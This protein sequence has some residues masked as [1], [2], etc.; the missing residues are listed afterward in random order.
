MIATRLRYLPTHDPLTL[1]VPMDLSQPTASGSDIKV[2]DWEMWGEEG[3][4]HLCELRLEFDGVF[5]CKSIAF[6]SVTSL[7][8]TG[9]HYMLTPSGQYN[10]PI[11]TLPNFSSFLPSRMP[12]K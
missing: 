1:D 6:F 9:Q 11:I 12:W 10:I 8:Y 2:S 7:M 3:M 4:I 5:L